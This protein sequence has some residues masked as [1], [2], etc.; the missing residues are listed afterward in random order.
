MQSLIRAHFCSYEK[1]RGS[2]PGP[3]N[4]PVKTFS[5]HQGPRQRSKRET[6]VGLDAFRVEEY[7][8]QKRL[9]VRLVGAQRGGKGDSPGEDDSQGPLAAPGYWFV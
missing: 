8:G 2:V 1:V 9:N 3:K 4:T 5:L 6:Y 7:I